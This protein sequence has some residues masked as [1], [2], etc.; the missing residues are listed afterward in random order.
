MNIASWVKAYFKLIF[1]RRKF[2]TSVIH[3]GV[4]MDKLSE[5][6]EYSVLFRNTVLMN[7]ILGAYSYIQANSVINDSDIGRFCSIASDVYIGL[8]DHPMSMV[9]TSPIF[10]DNL[11]PLPR[12]L[13]KN[14]IYKEDKG[15]NTIGADVWIGRGVMIKAGVTVGVGAVI[16]AG[17]MVTKDVPPYMIVAGNPC[18]NIR[19]RFSDDIIR[20]LILSGWWNMNINELELNSY[21]FEDPVKFLEAINAESH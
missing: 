1:L 13:A 9:S 5:V 11:Q 21:L 7:S 8:A 19:P 2:P 18:R 16:G 10:Y 12:F 3:D 6:G 4:Y 15:R 17:S 20:K 14:R